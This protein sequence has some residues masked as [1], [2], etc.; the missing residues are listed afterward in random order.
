MTISF[1]QN[2]SSRKWPP[3]E[4]NNPHE[5]K[6]NL[7]GF[8]GLVQNSKLHP[9]RVGGSP[10]EDK[11]VVACHG[12]GALAGTVR[13]V[14]R[15]FSNIFKASL[16]YAELSPKGRVKDYEAK[17]Q[18]YNQLFPPCT[19]ISTADCQTSKR[20]LTSW[21]WIPAPPPISCVMWGKLF[22]LLEP[23]SSLVK[24]W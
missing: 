1:L 7:G 2:R 6:V 23:I 8:A 5:L 19:S 13:E 15:P 22:N 12:K 18:P 9:A 4:R 17:R 16:I 10:V 20:R 21:V 14:A 24:C 11:S 3:W